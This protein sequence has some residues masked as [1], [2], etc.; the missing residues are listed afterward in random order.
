MREA[1]A[2]L[3]LYIPWR[4]YTQIRHASVVDG[5]DPCQR[6]EQVE[7]VRRATLTAGA[8]VWC[9]WL[10]GTYD[11]RYTYRRRTTGSNA[12]VRNLP[13]K[14]LVNGWDDDGRLSSLGSSALR[15]RVVPLSP[16]QL[17]DIKAMSACKA[18]R[19]REICGQG[20][21]YL[22]SRELRSW[23]RGLT[24]RRIHDGSHPRRLRSGP[25]EVP[26]TDDATNGQWT[27]L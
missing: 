9:A 25:L 20:A 5:K 21:Q 19:A 18:H 7:S 1:P 3:Q 12:I 6:A 11:A 4:V 22:P 17:D 15:I 10:R 13:S 24:Y 14:G 16:L 23:T 2:R 26:L 8:S 27:H